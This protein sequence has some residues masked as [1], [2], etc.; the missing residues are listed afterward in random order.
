MTNIFY[1][2]FY[3]R[4]DGS[5][6]YVG[7]GKNRRAF[8]QHNGFNPPADKR[9]IVFPQKDLDEFD[10]FYWE[11]F[12]ISFYGRKDIGTGTLHNRTNG[13]QGTSGIIRVTSEETKAK[14]SIS[15]KNRSATSN[16]N[17]SKGK[18]G[19][20]P[21][22]KGRKETREDVLKRQ[23]ESHQNP[24][25]EV[26]KK[27][28]DGHRGKTH[29]DD[30]KQRMSD[31]KKGKPPNNKGKKMPIVICPHCNKSGGSSGMKKYH[32]DRCKFKLT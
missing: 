10:A 3:L 13:G 14:Q 22:N 25:E 6:Y 4:K 29:S 7:K 32:F 11:R 23:S 19:S 21:W 5:P 27:N 8:N 12:W 24:S 20:K 2:Y 31:K 17:I 30:T 18:K 26:R 28:A 1:V 15:A 16:A 9:R